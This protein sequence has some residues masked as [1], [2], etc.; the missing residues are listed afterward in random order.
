ML[1]GALHRRA[2][3]SDRIALALRG[4]DGHFLMAHALQVG[5]PSSLWLD[6]YI[7]RTALNLL[8]LFTGALN[9]LIP[10]RVDTLHAE[11][12]Y[13]ICWRW[14][15]LRI[16]MPRR[17]PPRMSILLEK[18][19]TVYTDVHLVISAQNPS[20]DSRLSH[21]YSAAWN[22]SDGRR[23][24]TS[25]SRHASCTAWRFSTSTSVWDAVS[26]A[27]W[28]LKLMGA[29]R[30]AELQVPTLW[31]HQDF[32]CPANASEIPQHCVYFSCCA[33]GSLLDPPWQFA[34]GCLAG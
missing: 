14:T 13:D 11:P 1:A 6:D 24:Y 20:D 27:P 29:P 2:T 28:P 33:Q 15:N 10:G 12:K 21:T 17:L 31:L 7:I 18:R 19:A 32:S 5:H 16:P 22:C 4:W 30:P 25:E 26:C 8:S 3:L 23:Q 9:R 34:L